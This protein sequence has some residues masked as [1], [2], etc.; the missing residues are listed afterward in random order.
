M[1]FQ[2]TEQRNESVQIVTHCL[3][4]LDPFFRRF[5]FEL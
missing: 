3:P 1:D 5:N 4:L 2:V